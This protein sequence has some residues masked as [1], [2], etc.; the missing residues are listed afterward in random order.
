MATLDFFAPHNDSFFPLKK[1]KNPFVP[2][3]S[4]SL[5][6]HQVAKICPKQ[7]IASYVL[8]THHPHACTSPII[9]PIICVLQMK[10][11]GYQRKFETCQ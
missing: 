11:S 6:S 10:G 9:L 1:K 4:F 7:N 5:L 3:A 2:L 8:T